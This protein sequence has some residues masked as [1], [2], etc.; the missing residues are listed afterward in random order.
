MQRLNMQNTNTTFEYPKVPHG[1]IL[2]EHL[3]YKITRSVWQTQ[4]SV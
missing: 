2:Q 4:N 1:H 3:L